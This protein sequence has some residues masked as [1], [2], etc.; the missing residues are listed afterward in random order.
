ML[1]IASSRNWYSIPCASPWPE[2]RST[3]SMKTPQATENAVRNDRNL[4]ALIV[5]R[6]SCQVSRSSM[7]GQYVGVLDAPVLQADDAA[8]H[9][10]NVVLVRHDDHRDAARVDL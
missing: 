7:G 1:L 8:G 3:M 2:P 6:I 4:F 10:G 9:R 5:S